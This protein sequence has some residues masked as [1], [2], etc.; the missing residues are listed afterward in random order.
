M[1]NI[2]MNIDFQEKK[3]S[4]VEGMKLVEILNI[5]RKVDKKNWEH[6][7]IVNNMI[8]LEQNPSKE[9]WKNNPFD[10]I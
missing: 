3:I 8:I 7:I 4:N 10:K 5:I 2:K 1:S 9:G 6:Y